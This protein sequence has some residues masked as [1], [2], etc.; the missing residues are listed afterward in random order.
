MTS[1]SD[2][3][4]SAAGV[5][6]R[7]RRR[8]P[9]RR[10][11]ARPASAAPSPRRRGRPTGRPSGETRDRGRSPSYQSR[12]AAWNAGTA[13]AVAARVPRRRLR[14]RLIAVIRAAGAPA[15]RHRPSRP[16]R[17]TPRRRPAAERQLGPRRGDEHRHV[18]IDV[19][20]RQVRDHR[21]MEA[22][23]RQ[24]GRER[25]TSASVIAMNGAA[26]L[27]RQPDDALLRRR[28]D[29]RTSPRG[30]RPRTPGSP[31]SRLG[32]DRAPPAVDRCRGHEREQ[33]RHVRR[34][35]EAGVVDV[36][37]ADRLERVGQLDRDNDR[38]PAAH[39]VHLL[40]LS[41]GAL[42]PQLHGKSISAAQPP[43]LIITCLMN[44]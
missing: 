23:I 10:R 13:R 18:D 41:D 6:Y 31:R 21:V 12:A 32:L 3:A 28:W 24:V 30:T 37:E 35:A 11:R 29:R 36:V 39:P 17:A 38:A 20:E 16:R 22:P 2:A 4:A 1:A 27:G 14:C 43:M 42:E 19:C 15:I 26:R 44:V 40:I 25:V 9:R 34:N 5:G 7:A 33:Q 8:P